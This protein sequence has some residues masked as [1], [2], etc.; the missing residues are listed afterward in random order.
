MGLKR[1]YREEHVR[2]P[3]KTS[4]LEDSP[5]H[6][7]YERTAQ[8]PAYSAGDS[9]QEVEENDFEVG[10]ETVSQTENRDFVSAGTPKDEEDFSSFKFGDLKNMP[11]IEDMPGLD[12]LPD[13]DFGDLDIEGLLKS[14]ENMPGFD[15]DKMPSMEELMAPPKPDYLV[16]SIAFV[17]GITIILSCVCCCVCIFRRLIRCVA[18]FLT[19]D[20]GV[21]ETTTDKKTDEVKKGSKKADKKSDSEA[22]D[23]SEKADKVKLLKPSSK[24]GSPTSSDTEYSKES[25]PEKT[26]EKLRKRKGKRNKKED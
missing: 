3:F 24:A 11:G 9:A 22:S 25:T 8:S 21:E 2:M 16:I 18:R 20:K 26:E 6:L 13:L 12:N 19:K 7:T 15:P 10:D 4:S 23:A 5:E 1:N 14:I 17:I